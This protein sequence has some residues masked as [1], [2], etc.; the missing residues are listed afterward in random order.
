MKPCIIMPLAL[1][2]A[3]A[4]WRGA[5][6]APSLLRDSIIV[7]CGASSPAVVSQPFVVAD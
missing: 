1:P 5:L 6:C 3:L 4:H 7:A 2:R